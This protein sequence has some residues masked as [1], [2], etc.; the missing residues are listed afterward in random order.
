MVGVFEVLVVVSFSHFP[1]ILRQPQVGLHWDLLRL[2][3][4]FHF[5]SRTVDNAVGNAFAVQ[6]ALLGISGLSGAAAVTPGPLGHLLDLAGNHRRVVTGH[7][8][9]EV[10]HGAVRHLHLLPVEDLAQGVGGREAGIQQVEKLS[11][12]VCGHTVA[13][14]GVEPDDVVLVP[15]PPPLRPP[16]GHLR[17]V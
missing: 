10:R 8:S 1:I 11:P 3:V 13:P 17:I 7:D 15:P 14:G 2:L 12:N 6:R 9:R 5:H 16:L 4:H